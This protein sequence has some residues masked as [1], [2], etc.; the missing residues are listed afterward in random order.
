MKEKNDPI[1]ILIVDDHVMMREGLVSLLAPQ[2]DFRIVGEAG[3]VAEATVKTRETKPD[4]VLMDYSLPD[5]TGVEA[6]QSILEIDPEVN[7]VFLTVHEADEKLFEAIRSGA[8]G[9]LLKNI[10]VQKMLRALRG[11]MHGEAPISRGMTSKVLDEFS[12]QSGVG[13]N[14]MDDLNKLTFREREV[15]REIMTGATN[16][17]IAQRLHISI[18]TVKN[19]V[20]NILEKLSIGN[21][22]ELAQFASRYTNQVNPPR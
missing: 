9:Y 8:K 19:H 10:P 4:L 5:G 22:R 11:L 3:S 17:E 16:K 7:V 12:R 6:T 15:L 21:R 20:H 18:N 1:R 13:P 14:G 2:K